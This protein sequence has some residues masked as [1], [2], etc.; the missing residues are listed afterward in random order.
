MTCPIPSPFLL[1]PSKMDKAKPRLL[2]I[3]SATG[4]KNI[5]KNDEASATKDHGT[6]QKE[7]S[8]PRFCNY[9]MRSGVRHVYATV[10]LRL[11]ILFLGG[12]ASSLG[13]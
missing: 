13:K 2:F 5:K 10:L 9:G 4:Q 8:I 11:G 7:V 3:K 6:E 1:F 12:S